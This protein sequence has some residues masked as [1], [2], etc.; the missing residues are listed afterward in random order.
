MTMA[1]TV[2]LVGLDVHQADACR[3]GVGEE[4]RI[5]CALD[6]REGL[7]VLSMHRSRLVIVRTDVELPQRKVLAALAD[8]VGARVLSI[9]VDAQPAMIERLVEGAASITFG[10][11]EDEVPRPKSGTRSR[12]SP[13]SYA[14][15]ARKRG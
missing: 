3:S 4:R 7:A 15:T 1:D 13:G 6:G 5:I 9:P 8:R 12:V 2:L 14:F 10:G 11:G